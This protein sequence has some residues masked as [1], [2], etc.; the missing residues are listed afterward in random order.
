[1]ESKLLTE[2]RFVD[3][4]TGFTYRYIFSETE[5]FR[6]HTH[7]YYELFLML[8]GEA[9]HMVNGAEIPLHKG[10]LVFIRP[11]DNHDYVCVGGKP[12]SM[13]NVAF[14]SNICE[15]LFE[16]LGDGFKKSHLLGSFL[17]PEVQL[18][19]REFE[20]F[21]KR[22]D[23]ICAIDPKNYAEIG[24]AFRILL[25]DVFTRHFAEVTEAEEEIPLWLEDMCNRM[26][27]DGNFVKGSEFFFSLT[28]K[29][30]EHVSR[31]MKKH[32][33]MTVTEYINSLRL[34]YIANMLI[35][36]NHSIS[37]IIFES[38]FNNIS[39]A[40]EQFKDKYGLTMREYRNSRQ[41]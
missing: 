1:M 14:S 7:E 10:T 32:L 33:G 31:M 15:M 9:L 2:E 12:F 8:E 22:M 16:Y 13:L 5:Y 21:S 29:S 40:S 24:S 39:W 23:S 17:P 34:N 6:P 19:D 36:S 35:N 26:K 18:N 28:D 3:K 11:F 37:D 30:R 25:F 27:R 41:I 38:G 20:R 4:N